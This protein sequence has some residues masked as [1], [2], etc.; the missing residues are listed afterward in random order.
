MGA[1]EYDFVPNTVEAKQGHY[2]HMQWTG[3]DKNPRNNDGQGRAGTDRSNV[4]LLKRE[5][6]PEG[7]LAAY[8]GTT[9]QGH[10]GRSYPNSL[11]ETTLL[12]FTAGDLRRAAFLTSKPYRG[13]DL[14][15]LD[16]SEPY[17]DLGARQVRGRGVYHYFC[18]RNN[19]FSNRSQKGRVIVT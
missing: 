11:N 2:I 17:F 18:T 16:D 15:E 10:W 1:V 4:V 14:E 13:E 9:K 3:S 8:R 6:Y 12:G 7:T 5:A 19:N